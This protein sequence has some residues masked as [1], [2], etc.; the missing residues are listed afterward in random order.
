MVT[1]GNKRERKKG[2]LR[3]NLVLI[4]GVFLSPFHQSAGSA[5][6]PWPLPNTAI[7]MNAFRPVEVIHTLNS[8]CML[9]TTCR[10]KWTGWLC[11]INGGEHVWGSVLFSQREVRRCSLSPG[12]ISCSRQTSR[13]LCWLGVSCRSRGSAGGVRDHTGKI[14]S[15]R[16]LTPQAEI[17]QEKF[18]SIP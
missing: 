7:N 4:C 9:C 17:R 14:S 8:E 3:F 5:C 6:D 2:E 12:I 18:D 10:G 16:R 15:A 11:F 1:K 13:G